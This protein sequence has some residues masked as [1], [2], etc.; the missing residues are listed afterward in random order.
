MEDYE[1]VLTFHQETNMN[2]PTIYIID[3]DESARKGI[4]RIL[5]SGGYRTKAFSSAKDFLAL[6]NYEIPGCIMLD[7]FMPGITGPELQVELKER[8]YSLPIVFLSGN[9]DV[10]TTARAMKNGAVDFLTKPV[11]SEELIEA[12]KLALSKNILESQQ[13]DEKKALQALIDML[14]PREYSVMTYVISGL[15]NK[16]I[17]FELDI[18]TETVKIHRSRVMHKLEIVSVAEL[19]RICEQL[20]IAPAESSRPG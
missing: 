1:L 16:Q 12:V 20:D 18:S 3:D 2:A 19:V 7:V 11:D 17:A 9:Q 6:E 14:T 8:D 4:R 5:E 13:H 15:L 10:R